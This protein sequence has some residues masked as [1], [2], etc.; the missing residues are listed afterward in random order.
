MVKPKLCVEFHGTE[1]FY[2]PCLSLQET[3]C[4]LPCPFPGHVI[5]TPVW[6]LLAI[7]V[8]G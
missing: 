4:Q 6:H 3:R 1:T 7:T 8:Q 2:E 5:K